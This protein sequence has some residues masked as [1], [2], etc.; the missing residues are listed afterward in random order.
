M[1]PSGTIF[2]TVAVIIA[3]G[4]MWY[5]GQSSISTQVVPTLAEYVASSTQERTSSS[6]DQTSA[7]WMAS[8]TVLRLL[9]SD[10]ISTS[11]PLVVPPEPVVQKTLPPQ[12]TISAKSTLAEGYIRAPK[13][14]LRV[15]VVKTPATR[16]RGL[17]GYT[18]LPN[19]QGMLFIFPRTGKIDFWMR[20]M[21]FPIDLVWINKDKKIVGVTK[22]MSPESYPKTFS[23][24]GDVQFVI[25]VNVGVADTLGLVTGTR[26][27]F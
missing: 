1:K 23:S 25:E 20:D 13:G 21:N 14:N 5:V 17:S 16:E 7:A 4:V 10:F 19:D 11:T 22:N 24:P 3:I 18:S 9:L 6:T 2:I 12:P 15:I 27:T 8:S 26:L